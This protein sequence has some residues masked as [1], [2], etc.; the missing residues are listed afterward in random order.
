[1]NIKNHDYAAQKEKR[2]RAL[3]Y[4]QNNVIA[5]HLPPIDMKKK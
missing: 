5:N 2:N 3:N 1:M 4:W